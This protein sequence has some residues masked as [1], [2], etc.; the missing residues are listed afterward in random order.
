MFFFV[1][2]HALIALTVYFWKCSERKEVNLKAWVFYDILDSYIQD[3]DN[4]SIY[5][6]KR[7]II[8]RHNEINGYPLNSYSQTKKKSSCGELLI[9]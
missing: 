9:L 7:S 1:T 5:T 6:R 8:L 3:Q 2:L 4:V